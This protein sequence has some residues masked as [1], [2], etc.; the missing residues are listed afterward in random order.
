M[1]LQEFAKLTGFTPSQ[2]QFDAIINPAY[3]GSDDDKFEF[4]RKW[5]RHFAANIQALYN[6]QQR[7]ILNERRNG[8]E[9]RKTISILSDACSILRKE[10]NDLKKAAQLA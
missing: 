3:M 6:M 5:K 10:R 7:Q 8:E 4:C 1:L 2:E 9:Y